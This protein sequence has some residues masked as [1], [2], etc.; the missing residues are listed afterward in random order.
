MLGF[1]YFGGMP[2]REGMPKAKAAAL[3]A[4]ELDDSLAEAH[5]PLGVVSMLYD[6]DWA[7][8]E[9]RFRRALQLKPSYIQARIWYSLF[10]STR[11][12]HEESLEISRRAVELEPVSL[13]V[14]QAVS[15]SLHYAGRHEEGNRAVPPAA[16]HGSELRDRV[17]DYRPAPV[18]PG[19]VF[20]G[21]GGGEGRSR[22]WIR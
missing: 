2:A 5:S 11:K 9:Q 16:R 20:R 13:L 17:R 1:D 12:R 10:L 14:H 18:R 4:L 22:A 7:A 15:R 6:W 8:A 21:G 3:R 19:S